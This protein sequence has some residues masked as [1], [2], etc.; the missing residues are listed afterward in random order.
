MSKIY[1][2]DF[3]Q[4]LLIKCGQKS[5]KSQTK[6]KIFK[7]DQNSKELVTNV[8]IDI[9]SLIYEQISLKYPD[10]SI[11]SED[12][13]NTKN[14]S[15]SFVWYIEPLDGTTNYIHRLPFFAISISR[16]NKI[17]SAFLSSGVYIPFFKQLFIASG[18]D[19]VKYNGNQISV[20]NNKKL[21]DSLV[22]TGMSHSVKE[23]SNEV[24]KFI[25]ISSISSGTR[26][27]GSAAFDLCYVAAGF[28]DAYYHFNLKSWDMAAGCHILK[29][30]GGKI[31]NISSEDNFSLSENTLLATNGFLHNKLWLELQKQ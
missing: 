27:T 18:R 2:V 31:S 12:G 9:G 3:I 14:G 10:D 8:D 4:S 19:L 21:E 23:H 1:D 17:K 15:N 29:N 11:I 22:L 24:K 26:R 28:A 5:L 30:A 16:Y 13:P 6:I 25:K 20:S 7:K